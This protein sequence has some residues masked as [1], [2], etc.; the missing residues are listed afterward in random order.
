MKSIIVTAT[1][2]MSLV[3]MA[4]TAEAAYRHKHRHYGPQI[5][6][7]APVVNDYA[8]A[9]G[10]QPNTCWTDEGYGRHAP[11]SGRQ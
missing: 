6:R 3:A 2:L 9:W 8:G 4:A 7:S 5:V 11:C 1:V 10:Y